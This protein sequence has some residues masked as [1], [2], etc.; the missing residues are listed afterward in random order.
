[1]LAV[2]INCGFI[3]L[4]SLL[5]ILLR[6]KLPA[7]FMDVVMQAMGLVVL[8]IGMAS[9]I[10]TENTLCVVVSLAIGTVIGEAID[11]EKRLDA[12]GEMLKRKLVKENQ[13]GSTFTQGFVTASLLFCVGAMAI[14]GSIDAGIYRNYSVLVSKS[15]IDG[16]TSVSFAAAMGI[17]VAFSALPILIYEGGLV[18]LAGLV[19]GF[20]TDPMITEMSAAG[21]CLII[22]LGINMLGLRKNPVK[23]GNMLPAIF[24][25]LAY[26]PIAQ[27]LGGLL[28]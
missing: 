22:A 3:L 13:G 12:C 11:I 2:F 9:A 20:L 24:I 7:R 1:M 4:G 16:V 15:V 17:G 14:V 26:L 21:G 27:W 19:A 25:P 6:G 5:G 23:V 8:S 28:P 18:L 10:S